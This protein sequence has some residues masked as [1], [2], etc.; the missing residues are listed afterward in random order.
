L[1]E[2]NFGGLNN[3]VDDFDFKEMKFQMSFGL[4]WKSLVYHFSS[5]ENFNT[6]LFNITLGFVLR[7]GFD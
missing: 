1:Y 7:L 5:T 6:K 2:W 4:I 3:G